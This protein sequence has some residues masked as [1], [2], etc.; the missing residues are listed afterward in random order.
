LTGSAGGEF[1][2]TPVAR[3]RINAEKIRKTEARTEEPG[4][5]FFVWLQPLL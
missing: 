4:N 3:F 1:G 2:G 5:E